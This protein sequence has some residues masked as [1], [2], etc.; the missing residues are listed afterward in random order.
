MTLRPGVASPTARVGLLAVAG[1][2]FC[3][4]PTVAQQPRNDRIRAAFEAYDG[5]E[6]ARALSLLR[7]AINPAEGPPDSLWSRAVHLM[8]QILTEEGRHPEASAWVRWALRRAP[9]MPLDSV[10]FLPEVVAFFR[11]A[12]QAV[13]TGSP[14]DPVAETSW[15]WSAAGAREGQGVLR[16]Q[17]PRMPAPVRALV[18]GA[19]VVGSGQTIALAPGTYEI[20]VA[21][22]G[23]LA[24][25]VTREVLPGVTTLLSF[26]LAPP[27]TP[28]VAALS[29]LARAA[30][31]RRIVPVTV[32]RHATEPACAMAGFVGGQGLLVTTYQAIR[33]AESVD[34]ETP[35]GRRFSSDVRVVAYDVEDDVAVL[36]LPLTAGDSLPLSTGPTQAGQS[37]WVFSL[38]N[39]R[40]PLDARVSLSATA[41]P[42]GTLQLTDAPRDALLGGPLVS[43]SGELIGLMSGPNTAVPIRLVL[44]MVETARRNAVLGQSQAVGQ[45]ALAENHAYGSVAISADVTNASARIT[46]LERWHWAGLARAGALPLT[47]VGPTGRYQLDVEAAGR[48]GWRQE[49]TVRPVEAQRLLAAPTAVAGQ[50][51]RPA[52]QPQVPAARRGRGFPILPVA[53]GAV[54]VGVVAYLIFGGGGADFGQITISIPNP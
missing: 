14:G 34:V 39:C 27:G 18:Q 10:T 37:A 13:G 36:Q 6:T 45:V 44:P 31:V 51:A 16:V 43:A 52:P 38:A 22:E 32:R 54:A 49:F 7:A 29:E 1:A 26:N 47:F 19:G 23:Y 24:T 8:A 30:V 2:L 17:S 25:V 46:P 9:G 33:G 35:G 40:T 28:T 53:G 20:Q 11:A 41:G 48:P 5:F 15:V 21:A 50:P 12:R 42:A 3:A 4:A